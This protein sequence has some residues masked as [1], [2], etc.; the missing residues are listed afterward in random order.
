[1]Q[2][3]TCLL[4]H[5]LSEFSSVPSG[6][7]R[8]S[9]NCGRS[10][11]FLFITTSGLPKVIDKGYEKTELLSFYSEDIFRKVDKEHDKHLT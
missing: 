8:E 4:P 10:V 6:I 9:G 11:V 7:T 3:S 2:S 5:R 1:M